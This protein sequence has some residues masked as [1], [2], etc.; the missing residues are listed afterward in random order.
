M[1]RSGQRAAPRCHVLRRAGR[2]RPARAEHTAGVWNEAFELQRVLGTADLDGVEPFGFADGVSQPSSTGRRSATSRPVCG[3]Y[4]NVVALGEFLLGYRNE[5]GKYTDR[6]LLDAD[7][8]SA[9]LLP[10]E[11]APDKKDL[12]K[13]GTYLVMRQLS[14]DVRL[15]WRFITDE[16]GGDPVEAEKLAAAFVGRTRAGDPLVPIQPGAIAGCGPEARRHSSEPIHV[17]WGSGGRALS[18]WRP[19]APG[20]SAQR[21]FLRPPDRRRQ[22]THRTSSGSTERRIATT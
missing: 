5:Y 13:N 6:P 19:C 22:E 1:G 15:F 4:S 8:A 7:T 21:G 16:A 14:Q 18:R 12:G 11:D 3:D 9:G 17:R 10:A 20:Q 2:H